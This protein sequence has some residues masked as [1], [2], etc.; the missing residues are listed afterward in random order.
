MDLAAELGVQIVTTSIGAVT[1]PDSGEPS[2]AAMETVQQLCDHADRRGR[3]LAL[4]PTYDAGERLRRVFRERNCAAIKVTL[5]PVV[6]VMTGAHALP[7]VEAFANDIALVYG[8]D[9]TAGER[10]RPGEETRVG[11]ENVDFAE[12][13]GG[14]ED[15]GFRGGLRFR[16]FDSWRVRSSCMWTREVH[17][18]RLNLMRMPAV[19]WIRSI[20]SF[21]SGRRFGC[22]RNLPGKVPGTSRC[23]QLRSP[24]F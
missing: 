10:E 7:T 13:F 6:L 3:F 21:W 5:D 11:G 19:C 9:G 20:R 1:P 23:L 24:I 12:L 4:R 18:S 2:P 8:C 14:L 16:A 15:A 17:R 22:I